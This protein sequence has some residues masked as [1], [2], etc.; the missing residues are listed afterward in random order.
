MNRGP[1]RE[2]SGRELVDMM[3]YMPP[4][5][6]QFVPRHIVF[7]TWI[8]HL[9]FGYDLVSA[10]R[11]RN[12]V[13]LGTYS[14]LSYFCFCQAVQE[15]GLA[16]RCH[17]VDTWE[18]DEHT[19]EYGEDIY[20]LVRDHNESHYRDFS[21]LLR[22]RFDQALS[23]FE[24]GSLDLVHLDGLH[25]YEAVSRDFA[26]WYPKLRPGGIFLFHDIVARLKD[27]GVWR[28]WNELRQQHETFS[29]HHGFGLGVLRKP[30]GPEGQED[31][32]LLRLLFSPDLDT[33]KQLRRFYVHAAVHH[34]Q[35][36]RSRKKGRM[37]QGGKR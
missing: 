31:I 25:T 8:D 37:A 35:M 15:Q 29:F 18:G 20:R 13:E 33:H 30:G 3:V 24:D 4:S 7:S 28:F 27:F 22:M 6:R 26:Q 11:P 2:A 12:L 14:G 19:S 16:T 1:E 32:P 10:L 17:A 21:S 5:L 23:R 34:Q 36:R 9:A